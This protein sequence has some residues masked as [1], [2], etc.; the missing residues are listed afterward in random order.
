[1][2]VATQSRSAKEA[3]SKTGGRNMFLM[4]V[5]NYLLEADIYVFGCNAKYYTL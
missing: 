5:V 3:Q 4:S 1:M 2:L